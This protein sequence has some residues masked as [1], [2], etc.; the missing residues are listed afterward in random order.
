M[1]GV[2]PALAKSMP[3]EWLPSLGC[4]AICPSNLFLPVLYAVCTF[5]CVLMTSNYIKNRPES[6]VA[7]Q[8]YRPA[9]PQP[10]VPGHEI[11]EP[12]PPQTDHEVAETQP[13]VSGHELPTNIAVGRSFVRCRIQGGL[14][15][16]FDMPK[17]STL[18]FNKCSTVITTKA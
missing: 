6:S 10:R 8:L 12:Q 5:V 9:D 13:L 14:W 18:K 3:Y 2:I 11:T 17:G 15:D 1:A 7:L 4:F 16:E